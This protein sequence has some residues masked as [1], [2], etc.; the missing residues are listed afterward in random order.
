MGAEKHCLPSAPAGVKVHVESAEVKVHSPSV[1]VTAE[2]VY[3]R[4]AE[5]LCITANWNE[6]LLWIG[7]ANKRSQIW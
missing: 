1:T 3:E 4:V 6:D 5:D 2:R 7:A